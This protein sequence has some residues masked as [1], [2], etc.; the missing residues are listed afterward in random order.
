MKM[1]QAGMCSSDVGGVLRMFSKSLTDAEI[2]SLAHYSA[3]LGSQ[4]SEVKP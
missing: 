3:S 4:P 2:E 1:H